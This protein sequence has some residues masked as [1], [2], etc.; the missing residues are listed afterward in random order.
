MTESEFDDAVDTDA[1][2]TAT[3]TAVTTGATP[4]AASDIPA[5]LD[6]QRSRPHA[7]VPEVP[8]F[9]DAGVG[10]VRPG[11]LFRSGTLALLTP[12]GARALEALGIR[13]VVDLR[14]ATERSRWPDERHGLDYF[15]HHLPLLP[16]RSETGIEWP[17]GSLEV[18]L[19]MAETGGAAI[20]GTVRRLAAPDGTPA[21]V[22]CAVGKDRTGLTVAVVHHLAGLSEEEIVEDFLRSNVHLGLDKGPVPYLDENGEEQLSHPVEADNLLAALARMRE[23]HGSVEGYLLA[24]G[25]TAEELA[26]LRS[27][28][29]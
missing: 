4:A 10:T 17:S 22:H 28:L 11:V 6:Y 29:G 16:D 25:V 18:Y 9:R 1:A 5:R 26:A 27:K 2:V 8:N 19:F 23:L 7:A 24:H 12:Q 20:A 3:T 15:D 13:V 21:V 14:T